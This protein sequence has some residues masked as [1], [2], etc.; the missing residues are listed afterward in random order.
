MIF[1]EAA[2]AH[3]PWDQMR[4]GHDAWIPWRSSASYLTHRLLILAVVRTK[5]V[6]LQLFLLRQEKLDFSMRERQRRRHG[7][8]LTPYR[9]CAVA[10]GWGQSG[11]SKWWNFTAPKPPAAGLTASTHIYN[12][13]PGPLRGD[14]WMAKPFVSVKGRAG[15]K[16]NKIRGR[17]L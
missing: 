17:I 16:Q 7:G 9:T 5:S 1:D 13:R 14:S 6:E 2:R 10:W 11:T 8:V 12:N 4:R 3:W 15:K